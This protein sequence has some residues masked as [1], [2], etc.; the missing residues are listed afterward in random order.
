MEEV[1]IEEEEV[2]FWDN[3]VDSE[4]FGMGE[5]WA[6]LGLSS[7]MQVKEETDD[8]QT[9]PPSPVLE[10]LKTNGDTTDDTLWT[11][12]QKE[13]I[14]K[15]EKLTEKVL[16]S[17]KTFLVSISQVFLFFFGLVIYFSFQSDQT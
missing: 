9:Q 8:L 4:C 10:A 3:G 17:N 14:V 15:A 1:P 5:A 2:P 13:V 12:V 6:L 7:G 11:A 16:S